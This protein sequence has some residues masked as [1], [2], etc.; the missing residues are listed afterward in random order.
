VWRPEKCVATVAIIVAAGVGVS[1]AADDLVRFP[2]TYRDGVHYATVT[3]GNIREELFVSREAIDAVKRG[4]PIPSGT[5]ITMEDHRDGALFR[6][7]VM[8]K[9]AG[10]G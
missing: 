7:V 5:I 10:W 6:Y 3:R 2:E 4:Q 8:E 9:R 1:F